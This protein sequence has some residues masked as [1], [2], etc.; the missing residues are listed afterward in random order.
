[1][2]TKPHF[3]SEGFGTRKWP[4]FPTRFPNQTLGNFFLLKSIK[5][6]KFYLS[7]ER[8]G[9]RI[10]EGNERRD[11][12]SILVQK[13][14]LEIFFSRPRDVDDDDDDDDELHL[15]VSSSSQPGKAYLIGDTN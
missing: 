15:S 12:L 14:F 11:R 6:F 10:R 5:P 8:I 3:E 7:V 2:C 1:M 4:I 9:P 13:V